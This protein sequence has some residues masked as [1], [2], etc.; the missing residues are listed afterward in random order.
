MHC[1]NWYVPIR[2]VCLRDDESL[3]AKCLFRQPRHEGY[4]YL[5][6]RVRLPNL[7]ELALGTSSPPC[8]GGHP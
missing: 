7:N 5:F 3:L 4:S 2:F 6:D 1:G 8:V